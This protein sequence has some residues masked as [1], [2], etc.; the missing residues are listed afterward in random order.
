MQTAPE[1]LPVVAQV[2]RSGLCESTH[3]GAL[4]A[5]RPD[6]SRALSLG[7]P[8]TPVFPRSANKPLQA[9]G[10]LHAG[11]DLDGEL[12]AI[13]TASHSGEPRHVALVQRLLG[14]AGLSDADLG[15]IPDLPLDPAAAA[16]LL[17]SGGGPDRLHMNCS[18]KHA[19]MLATCRAAGWPL[20][21]YLDPGSPLQQ[22]LLATTA[23]LAAEPVPAVGVDGC[24]AP[25][26][27]LSLSGL[28][29]A[30]GRLVTAAPGTAERRVADAMRTHPEVVG[31]TGRDVTRL[32]AGVPGLVAKDGAEGVYAAA[33]AD[34]TAIALKIQDGTARARM[35]LLV[36]ALRVLGRDD[37]VLG[38]LATSAVLG[39]G[40]PV[41]EVRA[42]VPPE[43]A[44]AVR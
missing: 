12:L 25:V 18:G 16:A 29:R 6:G 32:M 42:V 36:A 10:M 17:R 24:G 44:V 31:G 27:A 1:P 39:G 23:E 38:A 8:D 30:F 20:A 15:N 22:A 9:A 7:D 28:A 21:G 19:A 26:L 5:L 4:V 11:L 14:L 34:G 37:E 13:A 40:Q 41:G 2:L 43:W 3:A 33:L 35:P